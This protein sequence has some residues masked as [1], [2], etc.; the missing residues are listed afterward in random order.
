MSAVSL[1]F[2]VLFI[3]VGVSALIADV[4]DLG[5]ETAWL[6]VISLSVLGIGG[7]VSAISAASAR[8]R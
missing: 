7:L 2:G 1:V 5:P 8:R 4:D 3:V 6:W